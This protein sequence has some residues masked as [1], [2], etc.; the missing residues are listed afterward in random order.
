MEEN[1]WEIN[2]IGLLNYWWYDEEEF[3]FS[4]GRMILRGTNGSGK[5]VTMQ[6]FIPLLLD[7][8]KTPER[9]DPFG[10]K[11]RKIEDYVLGYGDNIKEENTSYLYMEFFKKETQNYITVGM[12][13]SA[14]KGQ[15][16][17]FWGFVIKDGR[18]IRKRLLIIQTTRQQNPTNKTRTKKQNRRRRKSCRNTKRIHA[19]SK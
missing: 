3:K 6:S 11:S 17:K 2:K 1:R 14:K 7:G 4:K 19:T 5:S 9:L 12:G 16:V 15:G 10:N 13:L 8:K 18:R